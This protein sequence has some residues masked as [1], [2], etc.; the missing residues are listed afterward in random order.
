MQIKITPVIGVR[1]LA[2]FACGMQKD[3]ITPAGYLGSQ[4]G[5]G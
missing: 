4:S 5:N 1:I 2:G 3:M